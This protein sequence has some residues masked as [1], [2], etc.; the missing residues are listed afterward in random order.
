[1]V[2]DTAAEYYAANFDSTH[3]G[4]R[5]APNFPPS[6]PIRFLLRYHRRSGEGKYLDMAA[7]TLDKM[8]R[9]G[10]YDQVGGG[11]HRYSTD[12][13]WLV[14]HFEKMLYDNA[15]LV[16]AYLEGYQATGREEFAHTAREILRYVERDMTSP[17]GAFYS[18]TDA[19]SPNPEGEREEG[20]F[21]T[22]TPAELEVVLGKE[23]AR[24]AAAHYGVTAEGNFEGRSILFRGAGPEP[25]AIEEIKELLYGARSGRPP[26]LRDEKVLTAWNGLMISAHAFASLVLGENEYA[27]RAERAAEF[28]LENLESDGRL[29]RSWKAGRASHNAYLDDYAFL[30]AALIDLYEATGRLRWIKE[31]IR[32]DGVLAEHYEDPAGGFFL[33]S[34]DH[35]KLLAREKPAY[36]GAEPSGN[37]VAA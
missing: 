14:P 29:L 32:L 15:L 9:G 7:L 25:Q 21:F 18:A 11:F 35:E 27:Q 13:R 10:M 2:L 6:L 5:G 24:V 34:D 1:V 17:D 36:D 4:A 28:V 23:K 3:G 37:S 19:D 16:V 31:A 20:W 33:T 30:T 26:P 22:W 12:A 8:A